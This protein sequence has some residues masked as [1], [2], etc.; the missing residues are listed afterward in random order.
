MDLSTSSPSSPARKLKA[1]SLHGDMP[2]KVAQQRQRAARERTLLHAAGGPGELRLCRVCGAY[3][4]A[5]LHW[6]SAQTEMHAAGRTRYSCHGTL[7]PL[8]FSP[9]V[10][11]R[12]SRVRQ[13]MSTG[14]SLSGR[15]G[16]GGTR[17]CACAACAAPCQCRPG[18]CHWHTALPPRP[19]LWPVLAESTSSFVRP[20]HHH[21]ESGGPQEVLLTEAHPS[22]S[23]GGWLQQ[24]ETGAGSL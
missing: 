11:C 12:L 4:A 19:L 2:H 3:A 13:Y 21:A 7:W 1:I 10:R 15:S 23:A 22:L 16:A 9:A 24:Q 6:R 20:R 14:V 17:L 5:P 8:V 18:L